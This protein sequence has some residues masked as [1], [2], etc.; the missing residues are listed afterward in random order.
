MPSVNRLHLV[1][2]EATGRG[3]GRFF[4]MQTGGGG[5]GGR[6]DER[7]DTGGGGWR[8]SQWW[9]RKF[10]GGESSKAGA[11]ARSGWQGGWGGPNSLAATFAG[12]LAVA[13]SAAALDRLIGL[14]DG[15]D[16][17]VSL[18]L[19]A[20]LARCER[21]PFADS[22]KIE[23]YYEIMEELGAGIHA[24]VKRGRNKK[25]KELVAVK[26]I[27]KDNMK[28]K[29]LDREIQIL[30]SLSHPNVISLK[31]VFEDV[32]YVYL[33]LE[34]VEGGEL[35]DKIVKD[36][37]FSEKDAAKLIRKITEALQYLHEKKVCHR[38]LKPENLLLTS[39][40]SDADVKIADFGLSKLMGEKSMMKRACGTW[41]YWAPEIL[42]RQPYDTSVDLWSVGVILYIM[43]SGVH[44]FDPDGQSSDAQIVERILKADYKFDPE[45]WSGI[46]PAAKHVVQSLIHMDPMQ[47]LTCKQ[48]KFSQKSLPW[49]IYYASTLCRALLRMFFLRMFFLRIFVRHAIHM[50]PMQR[51]TCRKT[52][53]EKFSK[54]LL[55]S[56]AT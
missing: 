53:S 42:R 51:L 7:Q 52:F 35:F 47:R 39:K 28:P 48:A 29:Q 27:D 15:R 46:S 32:K 49:D 8:S 17:Q 16:A 25:T 56:D 37:A 20:L 6:R 4:S 40:G 22:R 5:G 50:D 24:S 33:V 38:D 43:L 11:G 55:T 31:D 1:A 18:L 34:L 36:G 44:P 12:C 14:Q 3:R 54:V 13:G 9:E 30:S 23:D 45:Y 41:A 19:G 26:C 2:C 21:L 10:T